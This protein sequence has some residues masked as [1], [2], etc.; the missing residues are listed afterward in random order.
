MNDHRT[1]WDDQPVTLQVGA[2]TVTV[3]IAPLRAASANFRTATLVEPA[4]GCLELR[5]SWGLRLFGLAFA[6]FGLMPFGI[7]WA[8]WPD[9]PYAPY[10]VGGVGAVFLIVGLVLLL[11]GYR[12]RFD[13]NNGEMTYGFTGFRRTRPLAEVLAVQLIDGGLQDSSDGPSYRTWQLNLV[14]DDA[15]QPRV[16]LANH[17]HLSYTRWAG[18]RLA[19]FLDVPLLDQL[20]PG[21]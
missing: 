19:D 17:A 10:L 11:Y 12:A 21:K 15:S 7:L 8:A 1:S 14:L 16:C 5:P 18:A 6:L 13:R 20:P 3:E 4:A 2:R 9:D